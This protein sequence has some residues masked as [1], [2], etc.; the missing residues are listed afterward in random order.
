MTIG[1]VC[2]KRQR[3]ICTLKGRICPEHR[4]VEVEK[5]ESLDCAASFGGCKHG[6]AFLMWT[7]TKYESPPSTEVECYWR[8]SAFSKVGDSQKFV[9][10]SEELVKDFSNDSTF[11][12]QVIQQSAAKQVDSHLSRQ[13]FDLEERKIYI[14]SIH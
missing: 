7:N 6:I 9:I 2:V 3:K 10:A 11:L 8:K 14:L 5:V 13:S 4:V 12:F 1:Y